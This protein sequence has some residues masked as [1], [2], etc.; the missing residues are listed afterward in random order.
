M[1]NSIRKNK[2]ESNGISTKWVLLTLISVVLIVVVFYF[3]NFNSHLLKDHAWW[4]VYQNLSKDTGT[5]GTFGDYIGGILNPIIAAFAFYLIA[6]TYEL[7][8]TEL[9]AT[10]NLLEVSTNAQQNQ[11]EL[12][13]LTA[14][15]DSNLTKISL[16]QTE[17]IS[18]L[19][20][21]T[22]TLEQESRKNGIETI[23]NS[24]LTG[25]ARDEQI[26][27]RRAQIEEEINSCIKENNE[28]EKRIKEF[29]KNKINDLS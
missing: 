23:K 19:Q 11:I 21:P 1:S 7:Q 25:D 29:F 4:S 16:L 20:G 9:K 24:R 14:L 13:A 28:L 27:Q 15:L 5:W 22:L 3:V 26:K 18:F 8:K 17:K 2:T 10:R 6:K 12:A